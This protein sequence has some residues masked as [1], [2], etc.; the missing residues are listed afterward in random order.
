MSL[1]DEKKKRLVSEKAIWESLEP[2]NCF[3]WWFRFVPLAYRIS[4]SNQVTIYEIAPRKYRSCIWVS[5]TL[6][7]FL[8]QDVTFTNVIFLSLYSP[9]FCDYFFCLLK[10]KVVMPVSQSIMNTTKW[11]GFKVTRCRKICE[12]VFQMTW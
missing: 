4:G 2:V 8:S 5:A 12:N 1:I 11:F 7:H 9:S 6:D 3:L 10:W